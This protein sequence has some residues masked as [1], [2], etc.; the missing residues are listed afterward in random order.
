ML[1]W[2]Y[3]L[4]S[5]LV[6][7]AVLIRLWLKGAAQP[8]YRRRVL[9]RF[10]SVP[11]SVPLGVL[12]IH[13]V[14]VGETIAATPVI[15]ALLDRYPRLP[16]LVTT[17]TPTGSAEV[18]KRFGDRVQHGYAPYDF[19]FSVKR[20]LHR[21]DPIGL[22]LVETE[23][24]PNLLRETRK[25][26]IPVWLI[27]ARL[28]ERSAR[29]YKALH[30]FGQ[31]MLASLSGIA[32]Q[33]EA[34]AERFKT[35]GANSDAVRVTGSIKFDQPLPQIS[36]DSIAR[37]RAD[38]V[39]ERKCWIAA[40]IHPAEDSIVLKAHKSLLEHHP[41]AKL[42]LAPR[43]AHRAS[44]LDKRCEQL[45]LSSWLFSLGPSSTL[46]HDV[47][48]IDQFGHL[49]QLY[50]LADLAFIGGSLDSTGGHNPIEAAAL[51]VPILMGPKRRNFLE[52][53]RK[54]EGAGGLV[55]VYDTQSLTTEISRFFSSRSLC[56]EFGASAWS[57]VEA[58]RGAVAKTLA[59]LDE[60][61]R[62]ADLLTPN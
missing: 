35:L 47:L 29:G 36:T 46:D 25:A 33:Y 7:P 57:V 45:G 31:E 4:L 14:S 42:V 16:L 49:A 3:R 18:C 10:G 52:I 9:E 40:S 13:C 59:L 23:L 15:H 56:L 21:T 5:L 55:T 48:L 19:T 43:H 38:W 28:S 54:F 62:D 60:W 6:L 53:C 39:G 34:T 41:G 8:E 17:T 20:F 1:E 32:C 50:P 61:F 12:W 22:I 26:K 24:W 44:G 11:R 37:A 58:N 30:S 27:N 2:A 51:R